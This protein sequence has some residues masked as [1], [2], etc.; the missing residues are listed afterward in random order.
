MLNTFR[1]KGNIGERK[2]LEKK[3]SRVFS[4]KNI[5]GFQASQNN[6]VPFQAPA[7]P[8]KPVKQHRRISLENIQPKISDRPPVMSKSLVAN[9]LQNN[10][11]STMQNIPPLELLSHEINLFFKSGATVIKDLPMGSAITKSKSTKSL[12][13]AEEQDKKRSQSLASKSQQFSYGF[14]FQ[15]EDFELVYIYIYI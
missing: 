12:L 13:S 2:D 11:K 10:E 15:P 8:I 9:S 7:S 14:D 1:E 4:E 3:L 6:P 5:S